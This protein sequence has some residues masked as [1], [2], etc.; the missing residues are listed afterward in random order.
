[1][2]KDNLNKLIME[3]MKAGD[4]TRTNAYRAIK[5]AFMNW[6]TA[7][8]NVGSS[9]IPATE[10]SIIKKLIAQYEDTAA[11]CNDG[12]HDELVQESLDSAL[13]LKGLI[14]AEATKEDVLKCFYDVIGQDGV[15]PEKKNMG[16]IIKAIKATL[17]N[18][19][20]KMVAQIVQ[21]HLS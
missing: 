18:A 10:I 5:T 16:I 19:D 17:P 15:E 14:P 3:A 1:M 20:G 2:I 6:E 13:I 11:Q 4:K 21:A 12:K 7:K 8:E 9:L